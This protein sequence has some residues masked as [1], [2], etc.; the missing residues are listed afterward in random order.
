ML[1]FV[2]RNPGLTIAEL[3]DILQITKQSLNRVLKELLDQGYVESRAG[4]NDRRQRLLYPTQAG[5]K[6]ALDLALMQSERFDRAL[7]HLPGGAREDAVEFLL[8]MIDSGEREKVAT[9]IW[10]KNAA[11]NTGPN[12]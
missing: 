9:L 10:D 7:S 4:V 8:A 12:P 6:L 1:H 2:N 3:L 5:Q 11:E